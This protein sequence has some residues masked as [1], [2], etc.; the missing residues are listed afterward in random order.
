VWND[1]IDFLLHGMDPMPTMEDRVLLRSFFAKYPH[2]R[3]SLEENIRDLRL[4][5]ERIGEPK[6]LSGLINKLLILVASLS[7]VLIC[8]NP[9][10]EE[11]SVIMFLT[12]LFLGCLAASLHAAPE[13]GKRLRAIRVWLFTE[14]G[15]LVLGVL[16]S[17][18]N[19]Q[20]RGLLW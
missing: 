4:E 20:A 10:R 15:L 16:S 11:I 18:A 13:Q 14:V 6:P 12:A 7:F 19:F 5:H 17:L 9:K 2:F 3:F 1:Y 8:I